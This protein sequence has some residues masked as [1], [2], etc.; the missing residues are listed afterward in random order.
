MHASHAMQC[1]AMQCDAMRCN[2]MQCNPM[3]CNAMHVCMYVCITLE[4]PSLSTS[5]C[6]T[7]FLVLVFGVWNF[8]FKVSEIGKG[9]Q[10]FWLFVALGCLRRFAA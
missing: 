7:F 5:M 3:Q 4:E 2:A 1:N 9:A 8:G 10:S 6:H